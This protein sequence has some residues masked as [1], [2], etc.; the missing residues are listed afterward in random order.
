MLNIFIGFEQANKYQISD[1][2]GRNL[3]FILEE[4]RGFLSMM[5]RQAFATHRPF[6]AMIMDPAGTPML[7]LRRPFSWINSRMFVQRLKDYDQY[8]PNQEPVLD[9]FAE[10]QQ[11]WHPWRRQYDLFMLQQ[12]K[13]ILS[14][15]S[16]PQPEP[17]PTGPE[18]HQFGKVDSGFL[19]WRFP[20]LNANNEEIAVID[21][22]FRGFGREIFTDTGRYSV[23]FKPN[24]EDARVIVNGTEVLMPTSSRR[25]LPSL[26]LDQRALALALAVNIDFDYFSR[27]SSIGGG[28]FFHFGPID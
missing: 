2:A 11:V 25:S 22:A 12:Q 14:L 10:V 1:E 20:I 24:L 27:H 9:T 23:K 4:P 5:T 17:E 6:K 13:R 21:R 26:T 18:F 19:A 8:T 15:A 16:E 3:G 7:W 28:G